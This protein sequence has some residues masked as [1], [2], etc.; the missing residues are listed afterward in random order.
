MMGKQS[1]SARV[2]IIGGGLAGLAAACTLAARGHDVV[3]FEAGE[4]FGGKADVIEAE[5]FRFDVGPTILLMPSVLGRIFAEAGRDVRDKLDLVALDPQWRSFFD[6]GSTL[7]LSADLDRMCGSLA[8]FAPGKGIDTAYRKFL[9]CAE[10]LDQI[11][12]R[13]FFWRPVGSLKDILFE[14]GVLQ[15]GILPDVMRL[16][17][18]QSAGGL[19]RSIVPE[20][21]VAQMLDHFI[22]YVGSAPDASPAVLCGIAHMQTSEGVW[23]PKGGTRAVPV[24]LQRLAQELGVE[25]RE[26]PRSL[27]RAR[28]PRSRRGNCHRARRAH[29][30]GRGGLGLRCC[31]Y[32]QDLARGHLRHPAI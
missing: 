2:G 4:R 29:R 32:P 10:T 21:R 7:D 27:D 3:L 22:Q 14:R 17:P 6:G 18:W 12:R 8:A 25:L 9:G 5:G 28:R 26:L 24:V 11:A 13:Y 31:A 16:H 20:S 1:H 23:Y 15:A 19:V 30:A